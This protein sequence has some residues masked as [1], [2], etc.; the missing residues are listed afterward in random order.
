MCKDAF[1]KSMVET[2]IK[3]P[4]NKVVKAVVSTAAVVSSDRS[5]ENTLNI[6]KKS[7]IRPFTG[8]YK[9]SYIT[10]EAINGFF[11]SSYIPE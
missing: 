10:T 1:K 4:V 11:F 7:K 3:K 2:N 5:K 6:E 9:N 8:D